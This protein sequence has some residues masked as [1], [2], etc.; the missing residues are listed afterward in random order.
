[1]FGFNN[2]RGHRVM[3][4]HLTPR[5]I[6]LLFTLLLSLVASV[7]ARAAD[8]LLI[9]V[10]SADAPA[11]DAE[12]VID[13]KSVGKTA[14]DGSLLVDVSGDGTHTLAVV[15]DEGSVETRFSSAAG[16]LIDA[17]IEI[18]LDEVFLDIY[19]QAEGVADRQ[20]AAEGTLQILV[21]GGG[22]PVSQESV[23]IAGLGTSLRTNASGEVSISLPRG[24]YRTQIA[25]QSANLR[26]VGGLTR[27]VELAI[28]DSRETMEV[29]LPQLEEV[30]VVASFDPTSLEVSERDT[31][32]IVDT[33]G[34]ELLARFA[35]SDVA[36]SVVRVP[37]ISVQ[38]DKYVF[39]RGLGGRYVSATLNNATMPST[40]PTKRTVPLDLF[41]S[42]FVSQLDIK[43]TFLTSMPGEST[44]GNLVINTKTFPDEAIRGCQYSRWIHSG[45]N[46]RNG[47]CGPV[48]GRF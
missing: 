7:A 10:F 37:G 14:L 26:V 25:E 15:T 28:N 2:Q 4:L 23:Y 24:R 46:V 12:V 47:F 9:Y 22:E 11:A 3:L 27:T 8:E 44:G 32:N 17:I 31:T 41:P 35:D 38:D 36:A 1:M 13:Q 39:I 21:T 20:R 5:N 34:V 18:D 19:S 42:N 40:N 45:F 30:Y 6:F 29:A 16:Q 48:S 43:K 33:I